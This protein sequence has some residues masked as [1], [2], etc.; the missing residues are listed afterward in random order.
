ML[1]RGL[2]KIWVFLTP[3]VVVIPGL[4]PFT[5][6]YV[7]LGIYS[8]V[9]RICSWDDTFIT[10]GSKEKKRNL[11][12]T[13]HNIMLTYDAKGRW[14]ESKIWTSIRIIHFTLFLK[15]KKRSDMRLHINQRCAFELHRNCTHWHWPMFADR[16]YRYQT[17]N[18]TTVGWWVMC[19]SN[20]DN[21]RCV[22]SHIPGG[23][24]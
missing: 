20:C 3:R 2:Y 7:I 5:A 17:L 1:P 15:G 23:P 19:L 24:T 4:T 8:L 21:A 22:T 6:C 11:V 10:T 16:F 13:Q 14:Q 18:V 12:M 9:A